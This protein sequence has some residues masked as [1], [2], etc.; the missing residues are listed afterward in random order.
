MACHVI[1]ININK[2]NNYWRLPVQSCPSPINPGLHVHTYDPYVSVITSS[3]LVA[4]ANECFAFISICRKVREKQGK[5]YANKISTK[6]ISVCF[7]SKSH[8]NSAIHKSLNLFVTSCFKWF[9]GGNFQLSY[10]FWALLA[11]TVLSIR[12]T[13]ELL[14]FC[15]GKASNIQGKQNNKT[16]QITTKKT[17]R[18]NSKQADKPKQNEIYKRA[19]EEYIT[20]AQ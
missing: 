17:T 13:Y 9:S 15:N 10:Y 7:L 1:K 6:E 4:F 14:L 20:Q 3:L 18:T 5:K 2:K 11:V 16:N 8:R 12:H 19:N